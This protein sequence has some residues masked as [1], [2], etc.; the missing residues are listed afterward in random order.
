SGYGAGW[1]TRTPPSFSSGTRMSS[2]RPATPTQRSA[3]LPSWTR[4]SANGRGRGCGPLPHPRAGLLES[5]CVRDKEIS[6]QL[7]M[8]CD[9]AIEGEPENVQAMI[10]EMSRDDLESIVA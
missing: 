8:L 1:D 9:V 3:S 6:E 7:F 5:P 4:P 2:T 10:A